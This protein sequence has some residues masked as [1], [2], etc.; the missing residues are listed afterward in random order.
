MIKYFC[1]G[2]EKELPEPYC[3][4]TMG[5][6]LCD[7]CRPKFVEKYTQGNVVVLPPPNTRLHFDPPSALVCTCRP[8]NDIHYKDCPLANSAGK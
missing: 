5:F 1:D 4:Y 8:V 6:A 7:A 2:C 3:L